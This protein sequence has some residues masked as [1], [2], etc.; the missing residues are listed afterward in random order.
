MPLAPLSRLSEFAKIA[1]RLVAGLSIVG[2]VGCASASTE[3][4]ETASGELRNGA[5]T[6]RTFTLDAPWTCS[7]QDMTTLAFSPA[8]SQGHVKLAIHFEGD[9]TVS[10][11][12]DAI[13]A[14]RSPNEYRK[15]GKVQAGRVTVEVKRDSIDGE[16]RTLTSDL[17]VDNLEGGVNADK[18]GPEAPYRLR[19]EVNSDLPARPAA[20]SPATDAFTEEFWFT[21]Y[22]L[23]KA[24]KSFTLAASA[25]RELDDGAKRFYCTA[26]VTFA[27]PVTG[28]TP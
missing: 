21:L 12:V 1:P 11:Q 4:S 16:R 10:S 9:P 13:V 18:E 15:H 22:N 3:L 24:G 2:L 19:Y 5:Q 26:R 23:G 20:S 25:M 7:V 27:D 28:Q 6:G 17:V 14:S 8:P